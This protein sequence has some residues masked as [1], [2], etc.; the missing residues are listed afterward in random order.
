MTQRHVFRHMPFAATDLHQLAW[1]VREY[2]KFINFISALRIVSASENEMQAEV[3]VRYK[4]LRESFI[5]NVK[6]DPNTKDIFV[7]LVRGP[8]RKLEN[9]WKFHT[10]SDGST[11]VEFWVSYAFAVPW[12]GKLFQAKQAKA[13][14]MILNA[15]EAQAHTKFKASKQSPCGAVQSEIKALQS[16]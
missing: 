15:F 2:P 6:R 1:D 5:T 9:Q 16:L 10:L 3:Q 13:E 7:S 4:I 14:Y 8:F 11:L 12:L